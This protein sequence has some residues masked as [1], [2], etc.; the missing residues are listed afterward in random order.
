[1]LWEGRKRRRRTSASMVE[2]PRRRR[3]WSPLPP[4]FALP[5]AAIPTRKS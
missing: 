3:V 1:L 5:V 2:W 4:P